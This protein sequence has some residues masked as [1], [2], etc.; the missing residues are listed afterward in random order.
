MRN[1]WATEAGVLSSFHPQDAPHVESGA[2]LSGDGPG[3]L[4]LFVGVT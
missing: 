2:T 4:R 3:A 1:R